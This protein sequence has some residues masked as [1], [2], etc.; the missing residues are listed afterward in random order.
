MVA[1][2]TS[3]IVRDN[4]T[5]MVG[6]RYAIKK[7]EGE[8]C[9]RKWIQWEVIDISDKLVQLN[10]PTP[11][12][13]RKWINPDC[14]EWENLGEIPKGDPNLGYYLVFIVGIII[15]FLIGFNL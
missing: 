9:D 2:I 12:G 4:T 8:D 7:R 5:I 13:N 11:Y 10:D 1:S 3:S 6:N 14:Y 15:G